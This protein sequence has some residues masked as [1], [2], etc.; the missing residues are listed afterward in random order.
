[1]GA[2]NLTHHGE[3]IR[4]QC[5]DCDRSI[6]LKPIGGV[7]AVYC[8]GCETSFHADRDNGTVVDA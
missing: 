5:P 2:N 7:A 4:A 3:Q 6:R 1:M 8:G